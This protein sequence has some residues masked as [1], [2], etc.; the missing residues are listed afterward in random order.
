MFDYRSNSVAAWSERA[1]K[2]KK[3]HFL[4][5]GF[6]FDFVA[7][8]SFKS[9]KI[10]KSSRVKSKVKYLEKNCQTTVFQ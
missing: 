4:A 6:G 1:K 9:K 3:M 5:L 2:S 8:A 10:V 7:A